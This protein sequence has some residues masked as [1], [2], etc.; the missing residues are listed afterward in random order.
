MFQY[1]GGNTE[2]LVPENSKTGVKDYCYYQ[3]KI[4][5]T[6]FEMAWHYITVVIPMR[7]RKPRDK[8]LA[9]YAV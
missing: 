9:E 6:C 7:V 4:R 1:F 3:S 2:I 5:P 8:S